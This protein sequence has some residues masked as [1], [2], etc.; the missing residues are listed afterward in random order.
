MNLKIPLHPIYSI[1]K[2]NTLK[3]NYR[4]WGTTRIK[5]QLVLPWSQTQPNE[6]TKSPLK[7]PDT[8]AHFSF[9]R[10]QKDQ[11]IISIPKGSWKIDSH[12]IFPEN[13]LIV[14][15]SGANIELKN[16]ANIISYS[17]VNL[18]GNPND[19]VRIFSKDSQGQG[20]FVVNAK[21]ESLV[22]HTIFDGL[23]NPNDSRWSITG[24][25]SFF[26]SPVKISHATFKKQYLGRWPEPRS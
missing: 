18:K 2:K 4:V 3:L 21:K 10:F 11:K 7:T 24:A 5:S 13:H 19:P 20:F 6:I 8:T 15:E 25:V 9:L 26:G 14:F 22:Q 17:P 23:K 16:S 1:K 12:L